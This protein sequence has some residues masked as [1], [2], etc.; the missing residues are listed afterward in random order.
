MYSAI[1]VDPGWQLNIKE[2]L[3]C[4]YVAVKTNEPAGV[5]EIHPTEKENSLA[6]F[7]SGSFHSGTNSVVDFETVGEG[8]PGRPAGFRIMLKG[9]E[10]GAIQTFISGS[11]TLWMPKTATPEER[12]AIAL[13]TP[14]LLRFESPRSQVRHDRLTTPNTP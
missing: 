7:Y 12:L 11:P 9:S 8:S 5:L 2:G 14:I 3:A 10:A 13:A 1:G 4:E 6:Y